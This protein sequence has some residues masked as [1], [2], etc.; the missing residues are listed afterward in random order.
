MCLIS[1]Q[2]GKR[3]NGDIQMKVWDKLDEVI[4]AI[5]LSAIAILAMV[6]GYDSGVAQMAITGVVALLAAKVAK[7]GGETRSEW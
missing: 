1:S 3:K 4:G 5:L 2:A 6:I 7:S